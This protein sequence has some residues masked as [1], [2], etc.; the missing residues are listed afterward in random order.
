MHGVGEAASEMREQMVEFA[1]EGVEGARE[2]T[3]DAGA[4]AST[5]AHN[6]LKVVTG[7]GGLAK[8]GASE[9]VH[10]AQ[11]AAHGIHDGVSTVNKLVTGKIVAT[12]YSAPTPEDRWFTPK[13]GWP[14]AVSDE[15]RD[16]RGKIIRPWVPPPK[17]LPTA[18]DPEA[19]CLYETMDKE[20]IG[21]LRLEVLEA[22][23]LPVKDQLSRSTDAYAVAVFEGCAARTTVIDNTVHPKWSAMWPRAMCFP[24]I[25]PYSNVHVGLFDYDDDSEMLGNAV[26]KVTPPPSDSGRPSHR[27]ARTPHCAC[28][29][30]F[31]L[32][33]VVHTVCRT[34]VSCRS[35]RSGS[36]TAR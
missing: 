18:D 1:K 8:S 22:A 2:L 35:P 26:A 13:R 3:H 12:D 29:L 4:V 27:S 36:S 32:R 5:V 9:L 6:P 33:R 24:I 19:A 11:D 21:E 20:T 15:P 28:A 23:N 14:A 7:V 25:N 31:S 17:M 34:R 10:M 16:L 30:F